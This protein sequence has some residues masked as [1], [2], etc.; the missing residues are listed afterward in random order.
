MFNNMISSNNNIIPENL[1]F[2]HV[3][4]YQTPHSRNFT[5]NYGRDERVILEDNFNTNSWL[6]TDPGKISSVLPNLVTPNLQA[7]TA[8]PIANGWSTKRL[9]FVLIVRTLD[10]VGTTVRHIVQGY[11]DHG[12]ISMSGLIDPRMVM[13]V[14]SIVSLYVNTHNTPYGPRTAENFKT[15]FN[16]PYLLNNGDGGYYNNLT[17]MRPVD[18]FN[19]DGLVNYMP[20]NFS[21]AKSINVPET[22]SGTITSNV[23]NN[24]PTRYLSKLIDSYHHAQLNTEGALNDG[25]SLNVLAA[26]AG[27]EQSLM[28][29][30]FLRFLHNRMSGEIGYSTTI[31][32]FTYADLINAIP[33]ISNV[34]TF[35]NNQHNLGSAS[36]SEY[37]SAANL[38]TKAAYLI[39]TAT[40]SIATNC[41][42]R[43]FSF[44]AY[45][46]D[47]NNPGDQVIMSSVTNTLVSGDVS[48][49]IS[50]F[51]DN[52]KNEICPQ[53]SNGGYTGYYINV[54]IDTFKD[55]VVDVSL[56]NGPLARY[57]LPSFCDGILSPVISDNA[58]NRFNM[59]SGFIAIM[60]DINESQLSHFND[61]RGQ[62]K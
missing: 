2:I 7:G 32:N 56:N 51:I 39:A 10:G 26:K 29:N 47:I 41:L 33:T 9:R 24:V 27:R 16:I 49:Q 36:N 60:N 58:N 25:T 8:I 12:D 52:F 19:T 42:L 44:I 14:N 38:E 18:I 55:V 3:G 21:L 5:L 1:T 30:H 37:W 57:V 31:N 13:V 45:N 46:N 20:N 53:L 59:N 6:N 35:I 11:T 4:E 15:A 54:E 40:P 34:E 22:I 50:R 43:T 23:N 62:L 17:T 48:L 61:L 28:E